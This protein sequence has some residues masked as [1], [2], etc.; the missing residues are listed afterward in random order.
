MGEYRRIIVYFQTFF[1]GTYR[2]KNTV[3]IVSGENRN[4]KAIKH[5]A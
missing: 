3:L 5:G 1:S 2:V 4:K